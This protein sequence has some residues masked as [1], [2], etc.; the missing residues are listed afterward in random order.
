MDKE[1]LE[2]HMK[3]NGDNQCTLSQAI[4]MSQASFSER[5]NGH[6]EFRKNEMNIIC[7]RYNL[8]AEEIKAIFFA[9]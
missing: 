6:T 8:S 2:Y 1:L 5:M 3:K 7:K 9:E 4:G